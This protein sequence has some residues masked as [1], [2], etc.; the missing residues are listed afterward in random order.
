[1][2]REVLGLGPLRI[3]FSEILPNLS[4]TIIVFYR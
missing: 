3:I 1:M 4:S 2:P